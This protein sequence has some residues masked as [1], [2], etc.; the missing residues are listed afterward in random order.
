[1]TE[2]R[3]IE[4]E[5]KL[6]M[7]EDLLEQLHQVL[8]T[9]QNSMAQLEITLAALVKRVRELS[10]NGAEIRPGNEKPPHY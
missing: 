2:E 4:I 3:L 6:M 9:Q 1:M 8:L 5:T 7:Q 10:G